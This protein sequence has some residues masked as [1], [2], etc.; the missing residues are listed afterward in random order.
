MKYIFAIPDIPLIES[1]KT[2]A[3]EVFGI[4]PNCAVVI[5]C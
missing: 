3:D 1:L 4:S 5:F 2:T